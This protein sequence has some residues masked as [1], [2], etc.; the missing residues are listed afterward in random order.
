MT[1]RMKACALKSGSTLL[2]L[3]CLATVAVPLFFVYL[4]L[5][6]HN[7]VLMFGEG[8]AGM[9][10]GLEAMQQGPRGSKCC[11]ATPIMSCRAL[12]QYCF[13]AAL[14]RCSAAAILTWK[15]LHM[16]C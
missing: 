16:I 12:D 2:S 5:R 15:S 9:L 8:P 3:A 10:Q 7:D 13:G 11:A 6:W 14:H 1:P 4:K